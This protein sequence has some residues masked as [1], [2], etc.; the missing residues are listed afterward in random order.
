MEK[1]SRKR[2]RVCFKLLRLEFIGFFA[3]SPP[4]A[5]PEDKASSVALLIRVWFW[6]KADI[7]YEPRNCNLTF[8]ALGR[9]ILMLVG[10]RNCVRTISDAAQDIAV[11]SSFSPFNRSTQPDRLSALSLL[12]AKMRRRAFITLLSGAAI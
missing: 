5:S 12:G 1:R 3:R 2:L 8:S 7:R 11:G 4:P 10:K 6:H 9:R